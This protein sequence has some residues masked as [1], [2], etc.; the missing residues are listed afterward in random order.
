[1]S[2][3]YFQNIKPASEINFSATIIWIFN[4]D[5]IPPHIGFS[6]NGKYFSLK[7]SGKDENI[8]TNT[9]FELISRKR[10]PTIFIQLNQT[11]TIEA[12]SEAYSQFDKAI[13][14]KTTCL[15]PIKNLVHSP[16]VKQLSELLNQNKELIINTFGINLP[17][18]YTNLPS[19]S[20]N[21][22]D[23]YIQKL[24]KN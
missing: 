14:G 3:F 17:L 7:V 23:N 10:I 24:S 8:D 12:L 6:T 15:T 16:N 9:I 13:A 22:I 11:I 20:V 19:Y 5:K 18:N 2:S 4:A 21:D 1:M